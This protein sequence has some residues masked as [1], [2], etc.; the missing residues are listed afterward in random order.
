MK[1]KT[2][3][4]VI[5]CILV[6]VIVGPTITLY[7][8]QVTSGLGI[9]PGEYK[10]PY[11][12]MEFANQQD[13]DEH[14]RL[15]HGEEP[16]LVEDVRVNKH[17]DWQVLDE[18]G[19]G[20]VSTAYIYV[21]DSQL[22]KYEGDGSAY[23]TGTD[24]T[25]ESGIAYWS[26]TKLK[27]YVVKSDAK[28]WYDVTVPRMAKTDAETA[29]T[30]PITLR[31]FLEI[32]STTDPTFTLIHQGTTIS[33]GG[34]YNKTTSGNTRVFTFSIFCEDDNTGYMESYDPLND[35][36]WYA[37]VYLKQHTG[38]YADISLT[39]WDGSYE[40]GS[41]MWYHKKV[42]ADGVNGITK[43]K[44][45]ND[46]KWAGTWSFSFTGD[47]TGYSGDDT[48]WDIDVYIYSDPD[49]REA[50][51]SYGPDSVQLASTFDVDIE[52]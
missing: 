39:G 4:L 41:A 33:D 29:T 52:D 18:W 32:G 23:K 42:T 11:C 21:Y 2:E 22:R 49:Y 1:I 20:G 13:L 3:Y 9:Q 35:I 12:G 43:Y 37:M 47:F 24:G 28:A 5:L 48:D 40:K 38:N 8:K 25:L 15:M 51:S 46:Y 36:N 10:C 17:I 19:G 45:G 30:I 14:I 50:K 27:V 34:S 16:P 26:D 7:W 31:F 6:G 44:V